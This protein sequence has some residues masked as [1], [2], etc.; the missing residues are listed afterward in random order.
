MAEPGQ[1]SLFF[2]NNQGLFS[3]NYLEHHLPEAPLW[4]EQKERAGEAFEAVKKAYEGEERYR[5][6]Y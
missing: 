4:R 5:E 1:T 2:L 6:F 3:N